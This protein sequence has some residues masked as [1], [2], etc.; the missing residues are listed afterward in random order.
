MLGVYSRGTFHGA[1][2]ATSIQ[3]VMNARLGDR[4]QR[5]VQLFKLF[6]AALLTNI[7]KESISCRDFIDTRSRR[8]RG[9]E[10]WIDSDFAWRMGGM[11]KM[12]GTSFGVVQHCLEFIMH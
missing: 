12:H 11:E 8:G 7:S 5:L 3:W 2:V 6:Q 1:A 9:R 10:S 4:E